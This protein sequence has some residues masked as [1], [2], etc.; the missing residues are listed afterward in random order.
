MSEAPSLATPGL[1]VG[2]G[3]TSPLWAARPGR[4]SEPAGPRAPASA[5]FKELS[6][7]LPGEGIPKKLP[8]PS[9][10]VAAASGTVKG[11]EHRA[12]SRSQLGSLQRQTHGHY[13][14]RTSCPGAEGQ[15]QW[16]PAAAALQRANAVSL[17]G[18]APGVTKCRIA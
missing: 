9:L 14:L 3:V 6:V 1:L 2:V 17:H 10:W 11:C 7:E 8:A 4:R 13:D 18:A 12:T 15:V 16:P 5:A